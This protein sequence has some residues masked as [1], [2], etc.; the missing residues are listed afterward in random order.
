[1][2]KASTPPAETAID[3]GLVRRLLQ[4][5]HPDLAGLP[6]RL[7]ATG[8]DNATYRLGDALAVRLPRVA[9]AAP[10]V[11]NEQR[12][13]PE[14][15]PRLPV[16]VPLPLRPGRPG[17]GYPWPWSVVPW[18]A[19]VT[20]AVRPPAEAE[21]ARFGRFL[22]RLHRPAPPDAPKNDYRG[23][24]L[25]DHEAAIRHRFDRLRE[26]SEPTAE[27]R[28]AWERLADVPIDEEILAAPPWL[29]GDL[30]PKNIV[31]DGEGR[32]ACVLD[33]GDLT[34]GD[35]ATDLGAAW[36]LFPPAAHPAVWAGYR[37]EGGRLSGATLE[38]ARG[39][40]VHF[41]VI[42]LLAGL[43]DEDREFTAV[44]RR[45]LARAV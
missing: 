22:G 1:M 5:Q 33:W 10:L 17:E 30:H 39:W 3:E 14:L 44:G 27:V 16:P 12:W 45:T 36:M 25:R 13:L 8:W 35:P 43:I 9:S 31:V 41:A 23:V 34:N 11:R 40:A 42:L 21:A 28:A 15:A 7:A 19:G 38:R 4:A 24:P 2:V 26:R 18:T 6:L 37:D 29:H 20:A 32:L